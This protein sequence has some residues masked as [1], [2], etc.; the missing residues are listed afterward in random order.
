V[1][2]SLVRGVSGTLNQVRSQGPTLIQNLRTGQIPQIA[3]PPTPAVRPSASSLPGMAGAAASP[4]P[5]AGGQLDATALLGLLMSNPQLQQALRSAAV[6][7]QAARPVELVVPTEG[8][9]TTVSIPLHAVMN[10]VAEM[11]ERASVELAPEADEALPGYLLNEAGEA[12]VEP[13]NPPAH[14]ALVLHYFR[15]A[16]EAERFGESSPGAPHFGE[17]DE[18]TWGSAASSEDQEAR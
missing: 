18:E 16:G 8:G 9:P 14:A 11:A 10:T 13:S 12:I 1:A 5:A 6:L 2:G 15:M 3:G 17:Q 4:A 7:G